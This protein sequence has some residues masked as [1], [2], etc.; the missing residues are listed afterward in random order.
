MYTYRVNGRTSRQRAKS[1]IAAS[2]TA[3]ARAPS[4]SFAG[5]SQTD[6]WLSRPWRQCRATPGSGQSKSPEATPRSTTTRKLLRP[7]RGEREEL[8]DFGIELGQDVELRGDEHPE[9]L[10]DGAVARRGHLLAQPVE[11]VG[12][13]GLQSG[14]DE[15]VLA[16]EVVIQRRFRDVRLPGDFLQAHPLVAAGGEDLQGH[17]DDFGLAPVA[18]ARRPAR[19]R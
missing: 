4:G 13:Q 6:A 3:W 2:M 15:R 5:R 19:R 1:R 16:G 17:P 10:V 8:A 18:P 11:H 12:G 7:R 9:L 14:R